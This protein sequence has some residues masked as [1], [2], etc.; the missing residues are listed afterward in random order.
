[1]MTAHD[2]DTCTCGQPA[3][4][5]LLARSYCDKCAEQILAPIRKKVALRDG[6]G[7]GE[8][9][10][11]QRPDW[12]VG[13]ADLQCNLCGATWVGPHWER[14]T[15]CQDA[16]DHMRQW[17]AEILLRPE[18]PDHQ[19]ARYVDAADAWAERLARAVRSELVTAQQAL[20][21]VQREAGRR[22]VA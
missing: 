19:D 22:V 12:G 14:C 6:V 4:R 9:N 10:G 21:A 13:Y 18:L 2:L 7:F 5:T 17:Q 1:M 15:W 11:K 16:L 3:T 20:A 8:Q